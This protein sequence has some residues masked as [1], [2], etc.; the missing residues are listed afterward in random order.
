MYSFGLLAWV[1]FCNGLNPF[2]EIHELEAEEIALHPG[3]EDVRA[4]RHNTKVLIQQLKEEDLLLEMVIIDFQNNLNVDDC[5][6]W[7]PILSIIQDFLH[8]EPEEREKS[9]I[10]SG[11][12]RLKRMGPASLP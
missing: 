4:A 5:E 3:L 6:E 11:K 8:S 2:R 7:A 10:S 1:L 12:E 9:M